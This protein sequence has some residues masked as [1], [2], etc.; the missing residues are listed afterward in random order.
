MAKLIDQKTAED[1]KAVERLAEQAARAVP[2]DGDPDLPPA[3]G[4]RHLQ[5]PLRPDGC[6]ARQPA[7]PRGRGSKRGRGAREAIASRCAAYSPTPSRRSRAHW[8]STDGPADDRRFPSG[9]DRRAGRGDAEAGGGD[10]RGQGSRRPRASPGCLSEE[11]RAADRS[12]E[13]SRTVMHCRSAE[14]G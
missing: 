9:P 6:T 12:G 8:R 7:H 2:A 1:R 11:Q 5:R 3:G 13:L 10:R 14:G 4:R